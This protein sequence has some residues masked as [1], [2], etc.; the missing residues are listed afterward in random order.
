DYGIRYGVGT[1]II[2]SSKAH[3]KIKEHEN[4][5]RVDVSTDEGFEQFEHLMAYRHM[6]EGGIKKYDDLK[7]DGEFQFVELTESG[8][9]KTRAVDKNK[10]RVIIPFLFNYSKGKKLDKIKALITD[11]Q[12]DADGN[13]VNPHYCERKTIYCMLQAPH[14]FFK[15]K[16]RRNL[17][18]QRQNNGVTQGV[19]SL[20]SGQ[21]SITAEAKLNISNNHLN[22]DHYSAAMKRINKYIDLRQPISDQIV[23][24][25]DA[26]REGS[27]VVSIG[28]KLDD[29]GMRKLIAA[30]EKLVPYL[31]DNKILF[32]GYADE[33]E[34]A[35]KALKA[36]TH[37]LTELNIELYGKDDINYR[38]ATGLLRK[39][40]N[41][42]RKELYVIRTIEAVEPGILQVL[43]EVSGTNIPHMTKVIVIN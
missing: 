8:E 36:I 9:I 31:Y 32:A 42:I 25:D 1:I 28:L 6:F 13:F 41:K 40:V 2:N 38:R 5:Y 19:V 16:Y 7:E 3:L 21:M 10:L 29:A 43:L 26:K 15:K 11:Y 33:F 18:K 14:N 12:K 30:R 17:Y 39:V 23:W 24:P 22:E 27:L 20:N 4:V 35:E 34:K 37:L